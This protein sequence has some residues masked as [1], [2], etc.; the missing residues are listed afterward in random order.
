L[1]WYDNVSKSQAPFT[2]THMKEPFKF[3]AN[4]YDQ[5]HKWFQPL[6]SYD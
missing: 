3:M 2:S 1:S 6:R 4:V 5:S